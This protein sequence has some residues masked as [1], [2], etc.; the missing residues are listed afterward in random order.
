MKLLLVIITIISSSFIFSQKNAKEEKILDQLNKSTELM[1]FGK[2]DAAILLLEECFKIDKKNQQVLF[3]LGY[4]YFLKRNF[5][6]AESIYIKLTKQRHAVPM[7]YINLGRVYME[8][9]QKSKAQEIFKKG[10]NKFKK[11]GELYFNLANI[12]NDEIKAIELYETGIKNDPNFKNNYIQPIHY[13]LSKTKLDNKGLIYAETYLNLE[14]DIKKHNEIVKLYIQAIMFS[15][16]DESLNSPLAILFRKNFT[17]ST[18]TLQQIIAF[19]K[20]IFTNN[21]IGLEKN[22]ALVI[23]KI[24]S[25]NQ[26]DNY[27]Y[28]IFKDFFSDQFYP[29]Y[30]KNQS[31]YD[32]F[33]KWFNENKLRFE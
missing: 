4:A 1:G 18:I 30:I 28:W 26:F 6:K 15:T 8:T 5:E 32:N 9:N 19:R 33:I 11:N 14:A 2:I 25:N 12:E 27:N 20:T 24:I 23:E 22:T 31:S 13:Y 17:K 3:D 21:Q 29:W 10:I 7:S 16:E